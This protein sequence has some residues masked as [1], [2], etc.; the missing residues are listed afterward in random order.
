VEGLHL[1]LGFVCVVVAAAAN[2]LGGVVM[3]MRRWDDGVLRYALALGAG[4]MLAAV[5]LRMIPESARLTPLAPGLVL[6]GYLLIHLF[7]HTV[8]PHFHFGEETHPERLGPGAGASALLGLLVHSFFDGISI[9]SGFIIDRALGLLLFA[10]IVLH[11]APEG[12]AIASVVL[13]SRGTRA[14]ALLAS[15]AVG[16]ASLL[17]GLSIFA[18][19]THVGPALALSA[20]VTLYVAAS[21]LVPEVNRDERTAIALTVFAGVVLYYAT[22]RALGALGI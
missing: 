11:K 15:A 12:F 22:E 2:L 20:G 3:T 5:I 18:V 21:D 4:F 13:A 16:A 6:G 1:G 9:G 14:Q 8:A 19:H 7:E 17:G 10:A